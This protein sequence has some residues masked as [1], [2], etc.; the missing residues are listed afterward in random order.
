MGAMAK[1]KPIIIE[2][3]DFP[4]FLATRMGTLRIKVADLAEELGVTAAAVYAMLAGDL[5]PGDAIIRK[6]GLRPAFILDVDSVEEA[7]LK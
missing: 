5:I 3:K 2:T 1:P 6:L 4:I 7:K